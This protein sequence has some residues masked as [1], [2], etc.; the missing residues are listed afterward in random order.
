MFKNYIKTAIRNIL[1]QKTYS[2]INIAGLSLGMACSILIMLWVHD[3]LNYDRFHKNA[4]SIYRV[5]EDQYYSDG[6]YHVTVTP[7]PVGPAFKEE[8]PE[9]IDATR[10]CWNVGFLMRY[11]DKAFFETG[12]RPVD[13]SFLDM[14]T[15]PF[16]RGDAATAFDN[17]RS[18]VITEELAQKYFGNDDPI[19]K[20]FSAN[21]KYDFV[22]TGVMT[23]VPPNS[24]L[25]FDMLIPFEFTKELV[26]Q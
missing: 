11:G 14:F 8:L 13:P 22:V 10:L 23:D 2:L 25:E 5:V 20:I 3:E 15:F 18:I 7:F 6:T 1:G 19:G 9:V 21:N 17:T 24:S 26:V 12:I 4:D 16:V